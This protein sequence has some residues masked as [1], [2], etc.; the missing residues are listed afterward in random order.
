MVQKITYT[1]ADAPII[2]EDPPRCETKKIPGVNNGQAG[3]GTEFRIWNFYQNITTWGPKA[4]NFILDVKQRSKY[5]VQCLTEVHLVCDKLSDFKTNMKRHHL[6]EFSAAAIKLDSGGNHAGNTI[7]SSQ[8]LYTIP[9]PADIM[10]Q[11]IDFNEC[12]PQWVAAEI[13]CRG[14]SYLQICSY[15][16]CGTKRGAA[17]WAQIQQICSLIFCYGIPFV[18]V[19]DFNMTPENI[20]LSGILQ[21]VNATIAVPDCATTCSLGNDIIDFM[22]HSTKLTPLISK[23][24]LVPTPMK[25]HYAFEWSIAARPRDVKVRKLVKPRELPLD[26]FGQKWKNLTENK[27]AHLWS[28]ANMQASLMLCQSANNNG[29]IA[30]LGQP[31]DLIMSDPKYLVHM[32][33]HVLAGESLALA[34]LTIELLVCSVAQVEPKSYI[35]R[36]QFQKFVIAPAVQQTLIESRFSSPAAN[37]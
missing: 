27:A 20:R 7:L 36:S 26:I 29:G 31:S 5:G 21:L 1:P 19:G 37:F 35:G 2:G 28:I 13:R 11:I 10:R 15:L 30:I 23:L 12:K 25:P 4:T 32:T 33:Q 16:D 8:V 17:N 3:A 14:M 34:A 24:T 6:D 9:I 22:I 18:W